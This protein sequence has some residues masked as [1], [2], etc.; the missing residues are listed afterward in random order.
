M[1]QEFFSDTSEKYQENLIAQP[2]GCIL[3]CAC[4]KF[5]SVLVAQKVGLLVWGWEIWKEVVCFPIEILELL[6]S[7]PRVPRLYN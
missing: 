4:S 2:L 7:V 5:V 1:V 3:N 6:V